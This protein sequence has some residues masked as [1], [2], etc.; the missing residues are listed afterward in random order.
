MRNNICYILIMSIL[1]TFSACNKKATLLN[2]FDNQKSVK[3]QNINLSEDDF[4]SRVWNLYIERDY[5]FL[6]NDDG[7]TYISIYDI[8]K[9][10]IVNRFITRGIGPDEISSPPQSIT[11]FPK[12]KLTYF[13]SNTKTLYETDYSIVDS[14]KTKISNKMNKT[15]AISKLVPLAYGYYLAVGMF[16]K[17]RYAVL[18]REANIISY[19]FDY[20]KDE[21][22][23]IS[24]Y[25][26]AMAY[27]G[28][29]NVTKD[30]KK[31]AFSGLSSEILEIMEITQK[32]E[33][34]KIKDIHYDL[35]KYVPDGNINEVSASI[36]KESKMAFVNSSLTS[37]YIYVLYSGRK[38]GNDFENAI[39]GNIVLV[40][41]WN[42]NP[43]IRY[44][45]DID[46]TCIAI[47]EDNKTLYAISEADDTNLVKFSINY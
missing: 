38:I 33:L 11:L 10:K 20:P 37:D 46:V 13:D 16:E 15:L 1:I 26:K 23:N 4:L 19:N 41:D 32:G 9:N 39:K 8:K 40:F 47:G 5:L 7:K 2:Q 24:T 42:G 28:K 34:L 22:V 25:L 21:M 45:L 3:H 44:N 31:I 12:N 36:K 43:I 14:L 35:A 6:Y 29:L 27:Q 30:G 18:N 17:G